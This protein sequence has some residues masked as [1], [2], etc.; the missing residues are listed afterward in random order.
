M[1]EIRYSGVSDTAVRSATGKGWHEWFAL[2]DEAGAQNWKHPQ[3]A[4]YLA[5]EQ[6][7]PDWWAQSITVGYEQAR[8]LRAPGQMVDGFAAGASRTLTA[9][10]EVVYAAWV[11]EDRRSQWLPDAQAAAEYKR[12]WSEALDRLR[13]SVEERP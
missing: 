8:G 2:L 4:R 12:F 9:P 13:L 10:P 6:G 3:I 5:G 11:D 1:D 7:A